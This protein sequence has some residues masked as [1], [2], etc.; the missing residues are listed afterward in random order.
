MRVSFA[1]AALLLAGFGAGCGVPADSSPKLLD[2]SALPAEL[3]DPGTT[4]TT[5]EAPASSV[6]QAV[7]FFD[8]ENFLMEA[9][10]E[11]PSPVNPREVLQ[12]LFLGPTEEESDQDSLRSAIP[13]ETEILETDEAGAILIIDL[14]AGSLEEIEGDLQKSA[15]AQIVYTATGVD[16]I[17]GVLIRIDG[18]LRQLPTDE[19][20]SREDEPVTRS[21]YRSFD[22]EFIDDTETSGS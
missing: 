11:V 14:A 4:T 2:E 5:T 7:Y 3:T 20:D 21:D 18:E 10:R 15:I 22:R 12:V 1:V 17:D 8:E 16:G 9:V 19:G 13:L 6:N